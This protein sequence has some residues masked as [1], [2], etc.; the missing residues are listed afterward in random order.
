MWII[1]WQKYLIV[2]FAVGKGLRSNV[3]KI[4]SN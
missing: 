1:D 2:A 4:V 3:L